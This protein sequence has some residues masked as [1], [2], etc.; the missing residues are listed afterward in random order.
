MFLLNITG[1]ELGTCQNTP[2]LED[3]HLGSRTGELKHRALL[4]KPPAPILRRLPSIHV[5]MKNSGMISGTGCS[6]D[7][8]LPVIDLRFDKE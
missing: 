6:F 5:S 2:Q 4:R 8:S 3:L 1:F 7:P